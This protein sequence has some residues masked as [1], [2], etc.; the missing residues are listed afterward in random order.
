MA[1]RERTMFNLGSSQTPRANFYAEPTQNPFLRSERRNFST[2]D[3]IIPIGSLTTTPTSSEEEILLTLKRTQ[4]ELGLSRNFVDLYQKA[5][6]SRYIMKTTEEEKLSLANDEYFIRDLDNM[7]YKSGGNRIPNSK[8]KENIT[9]YIEVKINSERPKT[10]VPSSFSGRADIAANQMEDLQVTKSPRSTALSREQIINSLPAPSSYE[11]ANEY[12]SAKKIVEIII[13][14]V[15][16]TKDSQ[17]RKSVIQ[18]YTTYIINHLQTQ[19]RTKKAIEIA[20]ILNG[21]LEK[22]GKS[23]DNFEEVFRAVESDWIE[24]E[25]EEKSSKIV[26]KKRAGKVKVRSGRTGEEG[27]EQEGEEQNNREISELRAAIEQQESSKLQADKEYET[28]KSTLDQ[29]IYEKNILEKKLQDSDLYIQKKLDESRNYEQEHE[30]YINIQKRH[31]ELQTQLN[32][33]VQESVNKSREL[34]TLKKQYDAQIKK[35]EELFRENVKELNELRSKNLDISYHKG[36]HLDI[37][38]ENLELQKKLE[39]IYR[40]G[41]PSQEISQN[42]TRIDSLERDIKELEIEKRVLKSR[43]EALDNE[44]SRVLQVKE[45]INASIIEGYKKRS[46]NLNKLEDEIIEREENLRASEQELKEKVDAFERESM[47]LKRSSL[48]AFKNDLIG[49]FSDSYIWYIVI[50]LLFFTVGIFLANKQGFQ[51]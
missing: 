18:L 15:N 4:M 39:E 30:A 1:E 21:Q 48:S 3:P 46:E 51:Q 5:I 35:Q 28:L 24:E 38:E 25:Y 36:M 9:R 31:L 42:T 6:E 27:E 41:R 32:A 13:D 26:P 8:W 43:N 44:L 14:D 37:L 17:N 19:V 29:V 40:S 22:A 47:I 12:A 49:D 34:E 50:C 7:V 45:D 10:K 2:A 11:A 23:Q 33:Q 20:Q 16:N